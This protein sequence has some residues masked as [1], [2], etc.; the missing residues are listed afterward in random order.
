MAASDDDDDVNSNASGLGACA[1]DMESISGLEPSNDEEVMPST[2]GS[3]FDDSIASPS[4]LSSISYKA[5]LRPSAADKTPYSP[6]IERSAYGKL[7]NKVDS[8]EPM[9]VA[10][11]TC[12]IGLRPL[13]LHRCKAT[14]DL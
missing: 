1:S 14:M 12:G 8:L 4:M 5:R 10:C 6:N 3:D 9:T 2:V 7:I 11:S 13:R